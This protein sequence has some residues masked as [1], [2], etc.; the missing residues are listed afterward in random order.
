VVRA[1]KETVGYLGI[2]AVG[3]LTNPQRLI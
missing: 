3:E 1:S 2:A